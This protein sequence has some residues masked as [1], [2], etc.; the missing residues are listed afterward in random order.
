MDV[1]YINPFIESVV[2][3]FKTM[4][5]VDTFVSKPYIKEHDDAAHN[6]AAIIGFSGDAVGSVALCFNSRSA[7]QI[8]SKFAGTEITAE[9]PDFADALGELANM[10][11]GQAKS[12]MEGLDISISL[13]RVVA[14]SGQRTLMS[15]KIPILALP[16]DSPLGRFIVE[17]CMVAEKRAV[18]AAPAEPVTVS[19]AAAQTPPQSATTA[20][21][22]PA[23]EAAVARAS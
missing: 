1:R 14:G 23:Q 5:D 20:V 8:A 18:E 16:C 19:V 15:Q 6:V 9:H 7:C 17:A 12:K 10:V 2:K 21:I 13:P 4:L 3:V 11:A 22:P